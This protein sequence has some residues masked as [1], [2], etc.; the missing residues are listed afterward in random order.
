MRTLSIANQEATE[1]FIS[2]VDEARTAFQTVDASSLRSTNVPRARS[3][4]EDHYH[5]AAST[6]NVHDLTAW[7][8]DKDGDPAAEVG[9]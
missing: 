3:S 4:P 5:I 9:V 8:G 6:R 1:R 2:M 7:L